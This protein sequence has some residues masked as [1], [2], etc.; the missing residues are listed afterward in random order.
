MTTT[1]KTVNHVVLTK[2]QAQI[3]YK[4]QIAETILKR[5]LNFDFQ[6]YIQTQSH[7][8]ISNQ[9]KFIANMPEGRQSPPPERQSGQQVG[10][11]TKNAPDSDLKSNK[12]W[13][14][15]ERQLEGERDVCIST[16]I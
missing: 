15:K 14:A 13:S 11:Q 5:S 4:L 6:F 7:T 2:F 10:A 1:I 16:L 3:I 12:D 8:F 9:Y